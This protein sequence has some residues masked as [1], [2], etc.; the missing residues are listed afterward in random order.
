MF[1]R[2]T[3]RPFASKDLREEAKVLMNAQARR[4][5]EHFA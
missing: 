4:N 2:R 3:E 1:V 5:G